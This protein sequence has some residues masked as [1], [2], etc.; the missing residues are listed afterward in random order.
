MN[1]REALLAAYGRFYGDEHLAV[2]FTASTD[3]DDAKRVTTRGWDK[4]KPLASGDFAAGLISQR[5]LTA[6]IAIVL[7][8]SNLVVLECDSEDDL[9]RL[10]ALDL[11]PTLTVRSSAPYKRHFYFRP[12]E[13]L[14]ALPYV[15]F[16][17]ESGK[18][19]ADSGRYFLAPPSIHPSGTIYSFL[20]GLGPTETDI[21]ELPEHVYRDLC[22]QARRETSEQR[23][24]I[25][26]EPEAKILA[27]QR[28]DLIFRYACMLRRWGR[29]YDAILA[30]CQAFNLER[31]EPPVPPEQVTAQVD[32]A[33]KKEGDQELAAPATPIIIEPL[34]AFLERDLPPAE[35]L[36]GVTRNGTNL[37]PRYGWVMPWG[38]EGSGKTS[39]VVDLLFHAA[40]GLDWLGWPVGRPLRVVIVINEGIPGGFQ[41]KLAAKLEVCPG[42]TELI[43]DNLA[44]YAS[45]W[46]EFTFRND[47]MAAH[48]RAYALDFGADYVALD[49]L[50]TVGSSGGGRPDETEAF[51]HV[52][53]AFGVWS[54]LGVIT[55][56]HSNKAGMVSGDWARHPDTV[57]HLEKDGKKPATKLTLEKARPADPTELGVPVL[58]EWETDTLG[59]T[60]KTLEQKHRTSDDEIDAKILDAVA[61]AEAPL[62]M[63]ALQKAVGGDT[64]RTRDRALE[65][66]KRREIHNV[67]AHGNAYRLA[68]GETESPGPP[69]AP[70]EPAQTRMDTDTRSGENESPDSTGRADF[71]ERDGVSGGPVGGYV[72][73]PTEHQ[74][75]TTSGPDTERDAD[76]WF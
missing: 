59:Y 5:G 28:R 16:R 6:N 75:D 23:D 4:A 13:Q 3:G 65:L 18:L 7:R 25:R 37:L 11:P 66:L 55:A 12:P 49:P 41:D 21:V 34:R 9:V 72:V 74:P 61:K 60:R 44:V 24:R 32:G 71:P 48:A 54:D 42:D 58:L 76:G 43:R 35:S 56:H 70:D 63:G 45:P 2:A 36:V 38:R 22:A 73:P 40:A 50:H 31:C 51:K 69:D 67:T 62:T 52:L 46:G 1:G 29:P 47:R 10:E 57:I 39:V 15:A 33:M 27:G 17:F 20:T 30:E 26:V 19:T 8:P 64:K 53:R 14:E 68:P